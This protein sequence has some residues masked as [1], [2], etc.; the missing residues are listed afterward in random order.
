MS[1]KAFMRGAIALCAACVFALAVS[2][3]AL[4]T[5]G[6]T[7]G[8]GA[9]V[10]APGWMITT[11]SYPTNLVPGEAATIAVGLYNIG[12]AESQPGAVV[13]DTLPVGITSSGGNGWSCLAGSPVVCTRA[14]ERTQTGAPTL[15]ST[16]KAEYRLPATVGAGVPEGKVINE[17]SVS[18]GGAAQQASV[19]EAFTVSSKP[20]G[21]GFADAEAWA[22]NANGTLDTEAGSHPFSFTFAFDMNANAKTAAEREVRNMTVNLPAGLVGNATALPRCTREQFDEEEC[23]TGSQIGIAPTILGKAG[24][25]YVFQLDFPVYNLVP[26]SGHPAEFGLQ[27]LGNEVFL[28]ASVRTGG[29]YGI[30]ENVTNIPQ[31]EI[32]SSEV[33]IWGA[34]AN[35]AHN[36]LRTCLVNGV[37]STSGCSDP[38][39]EVPFLTLPTSCSGP[40]E[41]S[42]IANEWFDGKRTAEIKLLSRDQEGNPIGLSDCEGLHF[43]PSMS[44]APDTFD[45]DTPAGLTVELKVPQE[46]LLATHGVATAN[47]EDT[48][49]TLPEGVVINPGQAAGLAACQESETAVGTTG[50]PSCPLASKVGIDEIETPLLKSS[51]KGNV[52]VLQSNPPHLKLLV[53]ASGE[54]VSLKLVGDV[55]LDEK[56]GRLVSTFEDT[57]EL[58]FT[59]FRLAF[60][61]GAQAALATPTLCGSYTTSSDFTPWGSPFVADVFPTSEFL[62]TH[63]PGSSACASPLPFSPQL[64]AG[65]T[66]DQAGGFTGFSMLLTRGDG[67]QRI[68]SLQ[69][70]TPEGLLGMI[71]NVPLCPEAQANSGTCPAASQIGHT[72]V[73]AGPG[74]YP[75]V[76]P[77]PGQSP[78]PIYLTAGYE[79]APYGLS[80]VVPL[81]VGPFTLA[82]QIVRAKIEV[83]PITTELTITT[84]PLPSIID[85][86]PAD[87]RAIDAVIDR[88]EFMFNPTGCEPMSFSGTATS[89]EGAT[90]PISS[91]FQMGSCRSLAFQPDF[92]VSTSAKTSRKDGASLDAKILYPTG[93]LEANQASSQ[94][95]VAYVKV[96]LPK[97][98]PSRL[99]TLQ[100]ACLAATFQ[101]NPASCPAASVVG[102]ATAVT[103]VLPEELTGPAYFVSYG[104]EKFPELVIELKGYGVTVFL[105]GE[106]FISKA[107]IT[108][109]TFHQV[110]DV[111]ITSFELKLPEGPDSALAA[112]ANLCDTPLS[113]PTVFKGHN[114]S[115][116]QQSTPIEVQGCPNALALKANVKGRKVK[117]K[118]YVPA[119]GRIALSGKGLTS[120]TTKAKGREQVTLTLRQRKSGSLRTRLLLIY[121]PSAGKDRKKQTKSIA[122]KLK[123]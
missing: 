53:A 25:E 46:A 32:I 91:H 27:I 57:P 63:G 89:T 26:P 47:I 104:G 111:P 103:P 17:V 30:T 74:P 38:E 100:K 68:G 33:T 20:A 88:P 90:A 118:V 29:D 10:P 31:R 83:N 60:S 109:S 72:V 105:H 4:A 95:N 54:G 73:E 13:T 51:L 55:N 101:A 7:S 98:L 19:T 34:P 102:S 44:V 69:F 110:P 85:G 92:K 62:I 61:G 70:K 5:T 16:E 94:A 64:T 41:Y 93:K 22:S 11:R 9:D 8:A 3:S 112:N 50:T 113:M 12:A 45:A 65:S 81:H 120:K 116:I 37:N 87:L 14:V 121:T 18:G 96:E 115:E 15:P 24:L 67:Q 84:D 2:A 114:G 107:G 76:V 123:A 122:L 66:T 40:E 71:S 106:T 80:I 21:F 1:D 99:S 43:E 97:Q 77:E 58:P 108:S 119:A 42:A 79:G 117:A 6:A 49:V 56:T 52:Y 59:T 28:D 48:V 86:I 78:A 75:L 35:D 36:A 23:P 82:T 39:R